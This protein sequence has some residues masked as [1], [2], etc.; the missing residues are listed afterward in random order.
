MGGIVSEEAE[1]PR[2]A[3]DV[4]KVYGAVLLLT[5]DG[6]VLLEPLMAVV[7][8]V[9]EK[10]PELEGVVTVWVLVCVTVKVDGLLGVDVDVESVSP[11]ELV[12][13][14][15]EP[16]LLTGGM[17]TEEPPPVA[18]RRVVD[19][20]RGLV[21]VINGVLLILGS[22]VILVE[23]PYGPVEL[24]EAELVAPVNRVIELLEDVLIEVLTGLTE[25]TVLFGFNDMAELRVRTDVTVELH[26]PPRPPQSGL[27][28]VLEV[29]EDEDAG[30]VADHPVVAHV[31]G[32]VVLG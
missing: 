17:G 13:L 9:D 21:V 30:A 19:P 29:G 32:V 22:V 1:E 28:V 7:A 26:S 16:L 27:E 2:E 24:A 4:G 20:D 5:P 6:P 10:P 25:V 8:A 15:T 14:D 31:K 23:F 18:D 12:E 11:P 3:L